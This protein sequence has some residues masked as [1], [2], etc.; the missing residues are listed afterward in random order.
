MEIK[1]NITSKTFN[2]LS[3]ETISLSGEGIAQTH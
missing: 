3:S 1:V 2:Q